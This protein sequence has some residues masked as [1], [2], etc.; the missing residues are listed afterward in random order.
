[1]AYIL[2][3][4]GEVVGNHGFWGASLSF[5]E[6]SCGRRASCP[7]LTR[8]NWFWTAATTQSRT[9][10]LRNGV[11]SH[12]NNSFHT[13][14]VTRIR[15]VHRASHTDLSNSVVKMLVSK[16]TSASWRAA[17]LIA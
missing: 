7:S 5:R 2:A 17:T 13:P 8:L 1:M 10:L 14:G 15:L 12:G 3:R 4:I 11:L 9:A 6:P 16:K